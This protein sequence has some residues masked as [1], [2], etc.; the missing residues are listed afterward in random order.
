MC[1]SGR[2]RRPE[3][4][5]TR[6]HSQ[7]QGARS[8]TRYVEIYALSQ[9]WPRLCCLTAAC[10]SRRYLPCLLCHCNSQLKCHATGATY[11]Q[12]GGDHRSCSQRSTNAAPATAHGQA[13]SQGTAVVAI[14]SKPH[15]NGVL[16]STHWETS[17]PWEI[18]AYAAQANS[19]Q[20][21]STALSH[22]HN[23]CRCPYRP[24]RPGMLSRST[25]AHLALHQLHIIKTLTARAREGHCEQP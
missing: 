23:M 4:H 15:C 22:T 19:T 13:R 24:F 9:A 12:A 17:P 11:P 25:S 7:L 21:F 2:G 10:C 5:Q 18:A 1:G 16:M 3:R 14:M 8:Y 20:V 6:S